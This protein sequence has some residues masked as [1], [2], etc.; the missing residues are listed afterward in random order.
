MLLDKHTASISMRRGDD[1]RVNI[2]IGIITDYEFKARAAVC[3]W[4]A[5]FCAAI[6]ARI[7]E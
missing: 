7:Q 2:K 3:P 6:I 1:N 4:Q 5:E